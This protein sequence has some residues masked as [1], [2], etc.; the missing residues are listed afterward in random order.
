MAG[1]VITVSPRRS[2]ADHDRMARRSLEEHGVC[3]LAARASDGWQ[4]RHLARI[5]RHLAMDSRLSVTGGD[6]MD[7]FTY[8]TVFPAGSGRRAGIWGEP[9]GVD[10]AGPDDGLWQVSMGSLR[11]L[12]R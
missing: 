11:D 3:Q 5:G 4:R 8:V 12:P 2:V 6:H 9:R 10:H 7:G 1:P